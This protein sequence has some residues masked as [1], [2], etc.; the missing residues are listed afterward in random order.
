MTAV[1]H[2]T[3]HES[4]P[5]AMHR[6]KRMRDEF[7]SIASHELRTPLT[8]LQL[9]LQFL[10]RQAPELA[11]DEAAARQLVAR[12]ATL[13]RQSDRL[14]LLVEELVD[15]A[16]TLTEPLELDLASVDLCDAVRTAVAQLER[17][18]HVA[19]SG[20][21]LHVRNERPTVGR[22]DRQRVEHIVRHLLDN[23]LKFGAGGQVEIAVA[24]DG[25]AA[26]LTVTDHGIG[27]APEDHARI[28]ERF[29]RAVSHRHYGG[30]GLGLFIVKRATEALGGS[31]DVDSE[32]G[33][34][35]TFR[36]RLPQ[37]GPRSAR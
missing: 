20:C 19:R 25:G 35:A 2:Q 9:Q 17:S 14:S 23:A 12:L 15:V 10:A 16:Q 1:V 28:F 31:V 13:Q 26:V 24:C 3:A 27:I 37:A 7:L 32:A 11:R 34:G 36:V 4:A 30:F 29:E 22:W 33:C 8:P 18:G 5:S 21:E 6:A